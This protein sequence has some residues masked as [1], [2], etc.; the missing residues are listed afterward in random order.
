MREEKIYRA[1]VAI[2]CQSL[3]ESAPRH[4]SART[5][6]GLAIRP[7]RLTGALAVASAKGIEMKAWI[8]AAT[9]AALAA[10]CATGSSDRPGHGD[11]HA[12]VRALLS[13]DA[14]MFAGFDADGDLRVTTAEIEAGIT[15]EFARADAN[16]DGSLQPIE[17]GNWSNIALGGAQT[18]PYRLDFDRNVDNLITAEEFHAEILNRAHDYDADEDGVLNRADFVRQVDRA[19]RPQEQRRVLPPEG[20]RRGGG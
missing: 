12:P 14:M 10:G 13:V 20:T 3:T 9:C 8:L 19:R 4:I 17:F 18:A 7:P 5:G 1:R 15:R 16:H 11:D 6:V 2:L